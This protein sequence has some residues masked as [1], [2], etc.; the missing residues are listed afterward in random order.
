MIDC[1]SGLRLTRKL[2][3][4]NLVSEKR[5]ID[6]L[7][8]ISLFVAKTKKPMLLGFIDLA[9]AFDSINHDLL[10]FKLSAIGVST[11]MVTFL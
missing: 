3:M 2:M 8:T 11:R 5:T 6:A 9:K 10:W 1:C 4:L 7:F